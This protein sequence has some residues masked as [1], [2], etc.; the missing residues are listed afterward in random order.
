MNTRLISSTLLTLSLVA[1][2]HA[3]A[4]DAT[5]TQ[6]QPAAAQGQNTMR[7]MFAFAD[8]NK[9][10]QLTAAEA[11]V[12]LPITSANFDTIDSA[13]RGWISIEQFAA[14]TQQ[15]GAVQAEQVFK[16]GAGH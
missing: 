4:A 13:K 5:S 9:D 8:Q 15:R 10:G 11:V 14:F 1:V 3:M 6:S 7:A 16:I 12:R 2:G